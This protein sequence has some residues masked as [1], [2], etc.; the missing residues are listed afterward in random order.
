MKK[1][2]VSKGAW[3][4]IRKIKDQHNFGN[5]SKVVDYLVDLKPKINRE[6]L[7]EIHR[8]VDELINAKILEENDDSLDCLCLQCGH[9]FQL[10]FQYQDENEGLI[11]PNC[12]YNFFIFLLEEN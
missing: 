5:F 10:G 12:K 6:S 3:R 9:P 2:L 11:C 1:I 4:T 8:R 7:Q